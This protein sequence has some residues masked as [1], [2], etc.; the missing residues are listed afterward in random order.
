MTKEDFY[1][2]LILLN[3]KIKKN[4]G[5]VLGC[6][7][8]QINLLEIKY[9]SLPLYYK[10]FLSV[11]GVELGDFKKGT[12]ISYSEIDDINECT[13]ELMKDNMIKL[14]KY[15]FSFLLHQG[16]SSLFFL[17]RK[18]NPD[19]YCYTEGDVIKKTGLSFSDYIL[20]E[21]KLYDKCH[22]NIASK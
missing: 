8:E 12:D 16:Y 7:S 22:E 5:V 2:L 4:G 10:L 20:S 3:K 1:N 14:P 13:I 19:V 18:D 9:G 21:V 15:I 17:D 11:M 6:T